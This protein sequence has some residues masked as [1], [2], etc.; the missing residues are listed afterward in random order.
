MPTPLDLPSDLLSIFGQSYPRFSDGEYTR[1]HDGIARAMA[2]ADVD[3]ALI[4]SAQNVGNAT[5]WMTSWPGTAEALLLFRPGERMVM[6]V[7]YYNHVPL[8]R[9]IAR[10]NERLADVETSVS[11]HA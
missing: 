6:F 3:Y 2:A 11:V 10:A 8:A 9:E 5:R 1:R 4:V 7:E